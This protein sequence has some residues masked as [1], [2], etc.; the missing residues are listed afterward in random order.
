M[1]I[2]KYAFVGGAAAVVDISLFI[3]FAKLLGYPYLL[4]GFITFIIATFV[5]Y[6]LSIKYV[7]KSGTKHKKKKEIFLVY[8]VSAVGLGL[9]LQVLFISNE[10][11]FIELSLSKV[12]ATGVVFFW[13]YLIRKHF[14]F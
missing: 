12:I 9:N 5:N 10:L 1:K 14:I 4:V 13:N 11:F 3:I 2:I 8:T 7:F 6:A